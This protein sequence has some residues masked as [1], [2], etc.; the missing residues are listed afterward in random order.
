MPGKFRGTW[1]WSRPGRKEQGSSSKVYSIMEGLYFWVFFFLLFLPLFSLHISRTLK[2][3]IARLNYSADFLLQ[4][5]LFFCSL[6]FITHPCWFFLKCSSRSFF[7]PHNS[8]L[9]LTDAYLLN[10]NFKCYCNIMERIYTLQ[11]QMVG[12]KYLNTNGK[13]EPSTHNTEFSFL[14][15]SR[16]IWGSGQKQPNTSWLNYLG[17]FLWEVSGYI[18]ICFIPVELLGVG[19]GVCNSIYYNKILTKCRCKHLWASSHLH[20][21]CWKRSTTK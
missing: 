9:A 7:L 6:C 11:L 10:S 17:R 12:F 2:L 19:G 1:G 16:N 5:R 13:A 20:L 8:A 14:P 18:G 15:A 4:V 3:H 21:E